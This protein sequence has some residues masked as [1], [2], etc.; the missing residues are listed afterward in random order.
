MPIKTIGYTDLLE[1]VIWALDVYEPNNRNA[2]LAEKLNFESKQDLFV[3]QLKSRLIEGFCLHDHN[4]TPSEE[5]QNLISGLLD[6]SEAA[7][8][9]ILSKVLIAPFEKDRI[10][11]KYL[12][13]IFCPILANYIIIFR[14]YSNVVPSA[15]HLDNL[16]K[17]AQSNDISLAVRELLLEIID[18][19]ECESYRDDMIDF[20]REIRPGRTQRRT[21]ILQKISIARTTCKDFLEHESKTKNKRLTE[22]YKTKHLKPLDELQ[23]A[24]LICRAMLYFEMKTGLWA[25]LARQY[26]KYDAT[27]IHDER[28]KSFAEDILS[29]IKYKHMNGC[30]LNSSTRKHIEKLWIHASQDIPPIKDV[31]TN[32]TIETL[33]YLLGDHSQKNCPFADSSKIDKFIQEIISNQKK[34]YLHPYMKTLQAIYLIQENKLNE[35]KILLE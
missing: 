25:Y 8:S 16:L 1:H 4:G 26:Q 6:F 23:D 14:L 2:R 15:L 3:E 17:T 34:W 5:G 13:Y 33:Y 27:F 35:A 7:A 30:A 18:K 12:K 24:Y 20:I 29:A 9:F 19:P 11:K 31:R 28:I 10:H 32:K 21:T 22:E